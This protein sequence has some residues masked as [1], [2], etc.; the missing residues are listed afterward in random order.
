[1]TL[2]AGMQPPEHVLMADVTTVRRHVRGEKLISP[3]REAQP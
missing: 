1:L 3:S 2:D